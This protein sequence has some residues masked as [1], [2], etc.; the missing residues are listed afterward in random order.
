MEKTVGILG[1]MGPEASAA[2]FR[3]VIR[4]TPARKDQDHLRIIVFNNPK[5][6]D[7][8]AFLKNHG[9]SPLPQLIETARGL[10]RAGA[11][12]ISI[13]CNTAHFFWREIQQAV[14]IPVLNIIEVSAEAAVSASG[15][16]A[17][18]AIGILATR[19]TVVAGLYQNAL[20]ER[21]RSSLVPGDAVQEEVSECIELVK[22][23]GDTERATLLLG[24]GISDLRSRGAAALIYG[25][26]EL[27][28]IPCRSPLPVVDSLKVLARRTVEAAL[29]RALE[30]PVLSS[31][32]G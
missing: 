13:P 31:S 27:G 26:T 25:C 23:G 6:P 17:E 15:I 3:E 30:D 10:A 5:I 16:S 24:R 9:P 11:D 19:G 22:F 4:L 32:R 2:F 29:G 28:L 1:G 12:L 20:K 8:T 7:R 14:D 18:E 21:S